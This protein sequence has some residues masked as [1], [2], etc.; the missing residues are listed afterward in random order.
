M[1]Q[2]RQDYQEFQR[3]DAE[4]VIVGPENAK[5][6]ADYWTKEELPFVGLPDPDHRLANRY[7]LEVKLLKLGRM[8]ALIVIDKQVFVRYQHY[9]NSMQDIVPN[10]EVLALLDDLQRKQPSKQANPSSHNQQKEP[11]PSL[12]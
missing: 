7:G 9:G 11:E 5:A 2:L 10:A 1:A 4:V 8:P 12:T 3:R 6:F